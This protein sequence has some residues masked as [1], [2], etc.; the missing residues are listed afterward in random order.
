[1]H[2]L[3]FVDLADIQELQKNRN[4]QYFQDQIQKIKGGSQH[5]IL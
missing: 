3:F 1:M 2:Q 4:R 5:L